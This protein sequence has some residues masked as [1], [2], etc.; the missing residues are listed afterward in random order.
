[1]NDLKYVKYN[2]II[3][4]TTGAKPY[5][6]S[7][8]LICDIIFNTDGLKANKNYIREGDIIPLEANHVDKMIARNERKIKKAQEGL[9][10]L[11]EL[12]KTL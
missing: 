7:P 1:M 2:S 11:K 9:E 12:R 4:T 10:R 3:I 6:N 8:R 5:P